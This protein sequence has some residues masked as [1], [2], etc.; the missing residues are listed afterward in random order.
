[1]RRVL[2]AALAA[3]LLATGGLPAVAKEKTGTFER[4]S[5]SNEFGTR[6]YMVYL[7]SK[8]KKDA[9]VVVYLHGCTQTA[10]DAAVGTRFNLLAEEQGFIAVYPEQDAAANG[11]LCWNWFLPEHQERDAGEP[12]IIAGITSTVVETYGADPARV[13]VSGASAGGAMSSIMGATYPD[14]FAAIG[15]LAAPAYK[16][17]VTGNLAYRAMGDSARSVPTIVFQGTAD[18]LV[19]YPAGRTAADQWVGTNDLADDGSAN[20]SISRTP[21]IEN[22]GF[23]QTPDPASGNDCLAPPN[24]FPCAGGVVGFQSEYPTTIEQYRDAE[25]VSVVELWSIHGLGHA[26]PGG[27]VNGS[28]TDPIGPDATRVSFDFFMS[29]PLPEQEA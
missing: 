18:S 3:T 6:Q 13:F 20:G 5:Y 24:S 25:G 21:E 8:L 16:G 28:F 9:P 2:V 7:P 26:Y 14:L 12:S 22:R 23:D 29:H 11:T 4:A 19:V 10:D 27:D 15:I 17:D 1:M